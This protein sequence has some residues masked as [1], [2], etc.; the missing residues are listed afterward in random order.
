MTEMKKE[1]NKPLIVFSTALIVLFLFL[2]DSNYFPIKIEP[3]K[4]FGEFIF[5]YAVFLVIVLIGLPII[6]L[7]FRALWNNVI[8]T[9]FGLREITF[10]ESLGLLIL[11]SLA[12]T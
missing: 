9:I 10:W 6:N 12:L 11:I 8:P 2:S 1:I 7:W 5:L 4:S 3:V